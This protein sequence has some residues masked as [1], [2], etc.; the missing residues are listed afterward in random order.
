MKIEF[1]ADIICPYCGLMDNRLHL[2]LD[3]FEHA[4]DV[5]V[6][7]RSFQLHPDLPRE[8]VTQRGLFTDGRDARDDRREDPALHRGRAADAE[9][10]DPYHALERTLG[11]TDHAHE[12]LAYADRPGPRQRDLDGDVPRP[13][14]A[15]PQAVDRRGG[16]RLRRRGGPG[17]RRGRRGA[18]QPALPRTGGGRPARGRAPRAPA[19]RRSSSST[20]VRRPRRRRHRPAARGHDQGMGRRATRAPAAAVIG[21]KPAAS[22]AR[23]AAPSPRSPPADPRPPPTRQETTPCPAFCAS[24][25]PPPGTRPS[26]GGSPTPSPTPGAARSSAVTSPAPPSAIWTRPASPPAPHPPT[27]TPR[28]RRPP[29]SARTK[30]TEEFLGASAYLFAVPVYNYSMPSVF[31]ACGRTIS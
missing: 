27:G 24:T 11:P 30:L 9:G 20:A 28:S 29:P 26:P 1:W 10:L 14:R 25:P 17:P 2:A 21:R 4:G 12:L 23:T 16:P 22:A 6:V 15:G 18:A 13:L 19:A 8:G 5:Q 7:H 3:R 31:K